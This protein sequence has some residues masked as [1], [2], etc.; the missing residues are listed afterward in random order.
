MQ[1][2]IPLNQVHWIQ[3]QVEVYQFASLRFTAILDAVRQAWIVRLLKK[4]GKKRMKRRRTRRKRGNMKE[5]E[6]D[7][8]KEND[9]KEDRVIAKNDG[10]YF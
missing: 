2:S 3:K 10:I 7:M 1:Q 5:E 4:E 9:E 8:K 6:D